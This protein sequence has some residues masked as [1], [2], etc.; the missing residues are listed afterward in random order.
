MVD[1]NI[2]VSGF[3]RKQKKM[4]S[5][6]KGLDLSKQPPRWKNMF[7]QQIKSTMKSTFYKCV[8]SVIPVPHPNQ[9]IFFGKQIMK[10]QIRLLLVILISRISSFFAYISPCEAFGFLLGPFGSLWTTLGLLSCK[11]LTLICQG[12]K[13]CKNKKKTCS[14]NISTLYRKC[15]TIYEK[16]A[17]QPIQ[18]SRNTSNMYSWI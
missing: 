2:L 10:S 1:T 9:Y 12:Q 6:K 5:S 7:F 13:Y 11:E 14:N 8:V 16:C 4:T 18:T 3:S 17:N 15:T